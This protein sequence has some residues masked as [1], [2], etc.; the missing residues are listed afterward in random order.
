MKKRSYSVSFHERDGEPDAA[1]IYEIVAVDASRA[2]SKVKKL[3]SEDLCLDIR[4]IVIDEV[5][6]D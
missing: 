1:G 2:I 4:D 5:V 6:I 3:A